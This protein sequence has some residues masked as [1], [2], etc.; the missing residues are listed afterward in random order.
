[1]RTSSSFA[2]WRALL[3]FG[4]VLLA[5]GCRRSADSDA[6]AQPAAVACLGHL[7]PGEGVIEIGAPYSLGG[8]PCIIAELRVHRGDRVK[9]G[10]I[11]AVLHN[12]RAASADAAAAA[13]QVK[14]AE[15]ALDQVRA[16]AKP[17]DI[18]ALRASVA[19]R[20]ADLENERSAYTRAQALFKEKGISEADL[21]AAQRSYTVTEQALEEARHRLASI[22]E[23]RSVDVAYAEDQ[24][25]LARA[26]L[27]SSEAQVEQ[28]LLR[29]PI[30]GVVLDILLQPGELAATPVMAIGD[31]D[32]MC[33]EAY[34][35][36]SDIRRVRPGASA[37]IT[38]YAFEGALTGTV[39]DVAPLLRSNPAAQIRPEAASDRRVVRARIALA[40]ADAKRVAHLSNQEVE[41]LITP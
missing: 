41:I 20:E 22:A 6:T 18:A 30:N 8:G 31:T 35:Y 14:I 28:T 37:T 9:A 2:P 4:L 7:I 12:H 29:A 40:P 3:A 38:S 39:S 21:E 1:M 32:A 34:I 24:V 11:L 26:Q 19:Q 23:V 15:A 17:D 13:A 33:V 16:G 27:A 36:D 10:Q 5:G 25:A